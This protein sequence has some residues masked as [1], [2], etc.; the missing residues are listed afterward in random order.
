MFNK[1][2]LAGVNFIAAINDNIDIYLNKI[3]SAK[4][5]RYESIRLL[6]SLATLPKLNTDYYFSSLQVRLH[7]FMCL[8]NLIEGKNFI[9]YRRNF[10]VVKQC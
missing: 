5:T 6:D 10:F 9:D 8:S 2:N 4:F 7:I 1:T 3:T